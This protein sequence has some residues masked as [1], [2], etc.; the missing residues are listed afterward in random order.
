MIL[1]ISIP[2]KIELDNIIAQKHY[3]E[4]YTQ[5]SVSIDGEQFFSSLIIS[6]S[7]IIRGWGPKTLSDVTINYLNQIMQT[8]P[9]LIIVG[10]G[11]QQH[12]PDGDLLK[13]IIGFNVGFEFM[14]NG[15]ACRSYNIL[16]QENRNVT[17]ALLLGGLE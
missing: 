2:M 14:D 4:S 1:F 7:V 12:F 11:L 16:L 5:D 15:A 6:S 17:V 9:E 3:I 8:S 10:T 13:Q